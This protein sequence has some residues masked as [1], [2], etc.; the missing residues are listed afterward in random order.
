LELGETC[1]R[2]TGRTTAD[3]VKIGTRSGW[4]FFNFSIPGKIDLKEYAAGCC[5]HI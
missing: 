1:K 3:P 4:H 5:S 2:Q